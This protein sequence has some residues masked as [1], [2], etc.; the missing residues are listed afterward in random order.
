MVAKEPRPHGGPKSALETSS[1]IPNCLQPPSFTTRPIDSLGTNLM[2]PLSDTL[3][4]IPLLVDLP[5]HKMWPN[6]AKEGYLSSYRSE[7]YSNLF[8]PH[9]IYPMTHVKVEQPGIALPRTSW[10]HWSPNTLS[11]SKSVGEVYGSLI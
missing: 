4:P 7:A 5:L 2:G 3:L 10:E 6:S 11:P 9:G 1:V 8:S